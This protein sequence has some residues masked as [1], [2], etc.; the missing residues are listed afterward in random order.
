MTR[1]VG[2][3][4][5][6]VA[7]I[8]AVLWGTAGTAHAA[9]YEETCHRQALTQAAR[10]GETVEVCELRRVASIVKP[11]RSVARLDRDGT[12]GGLPAVCCDP[13]RGNAKTCKLAARRPGVTTVVH[14]GTRAPVYTI[15]YIK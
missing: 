12:C 1:F 11:A 3:L 2:L 15:A 5:V 8:L 14:Y 7:I 6:P 9:T 13:Q 10:P 4:I